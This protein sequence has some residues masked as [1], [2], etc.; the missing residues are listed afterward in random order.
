MLN[1]PR[2][3]KSKSK[4][5]ISSLAKD[6]KVKRIKSAAVA[7]HVPIKASLRLPLNL[8]HWLGIHRLL[9][10]FEDTN[11]AQQVN[12]KQVRSR[13]WSDFQWKSDGLQWRNWLAHGTYMTVLERCRGCE[14]E[15]HLEQFL[16][17]RFFSLFHVWQRLTYK[18]YKQNILCIYSGTNY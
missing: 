10:E 2:R 6:P 1:V 12:H 15:P 3:L 8:N 11:L 5:P 14:F 16:F 18:K 9:N 4:R 13:F 7:A 17:P